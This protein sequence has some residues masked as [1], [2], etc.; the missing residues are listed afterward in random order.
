MRFCDNELWILQNQ[1]N[2]HFGAIFLLD[3]D[4][5]PDAPF[6]GSQGSREQ[7]AMTG[8]SQLTL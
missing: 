8:S 6:R 4:N 5:E 7:S 2:P 3:N 1:R